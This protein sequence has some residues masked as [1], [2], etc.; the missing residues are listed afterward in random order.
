MKIF[1]KCHDFEIKNQSI[2]FFIASIIKTDIE[3][4]AIFL[5]LTKG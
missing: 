5:P 3:K 1:I 2:F 4:Q